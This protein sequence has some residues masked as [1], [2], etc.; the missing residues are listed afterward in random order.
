MSYETG[1][2]TMLEIGLLRQNM[3]V[4][5]R[6]AAVNEAFRRVCL[7]DASEAYLVLTGQTLPAQYVVCFVEP[8]QEIS[9]G[10]A[11]RYVRLPPFF[12]ETWL[13]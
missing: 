9:A 1:E 8:E 2:Q 13:S 10:G 6:R 4:L 5:L 11:V 7:E 3:A 12:R